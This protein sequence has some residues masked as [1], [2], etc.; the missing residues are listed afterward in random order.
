M[1]NT[2]ETIYETFAGVNHYG[3]TVEKFEE[4]Y[5]I[6]FDEGKDIANRYILFKVNDRYYRFVSCEGVW[7][8]YIIKI[9]KVG[10]DEDAIESVR[11]EFL[12]DEEN[13]FNLEM[14]KESN[15]HAQ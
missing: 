12:F 15:N 8:W 11:E 14:I 10:T 7:F 6:L 13:I 2:I 1:S 9:F 5:K 3:E 4:T